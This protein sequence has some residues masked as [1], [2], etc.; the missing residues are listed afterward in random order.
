MISNADKIN[1]FIDDIVDEHVNNF[2][3]N[4]IEDLTSA[5]IKEMRAKESRGEKTTMSCNFFFI[6]TNQ[7]IFTGCDVQNNNYSCNEIKNTLYK[8]TSYLEVI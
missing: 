3:E 7:P 6:Y 8:H 5:Y 4:D 2:D 1:E